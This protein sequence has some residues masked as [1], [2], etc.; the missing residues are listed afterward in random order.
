MKK[1]ATLAALMAGIGL[2]FG[3]TVLHAP[4]QVGFWNTE[5]AKQGLPPVGQVGSNHLVFGSDGNKLVG[6]N[7]SAELYYLNT[8]TS[9]LTPLPSSIQTFRPSTTS[10]PGTWNVAVVNLPL[11]YGGVDYND[12]GSGEAGDGSTLDP[13]NGGPGF[14]PVTLRVRTWDT[15]TGATWEQATL[16][17]ESASFVYIQRFSA[18]AGSPADLNMI[19][20]PGHIQPVPEPSAIALSILGVA[21]LLLIRRR[22]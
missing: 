6:V 19:R 15:L 22:K 13:I 18:P 7:Y 4:G 8:D 5:T 1:L 16:R 9:S 17:G 14:Y 21:G 2:S 12:D 11:A 20:Q 10:L 3:Q